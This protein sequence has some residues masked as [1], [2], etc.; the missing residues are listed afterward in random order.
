MPT[1]RTTVACL[2]V[3]TLTLAAGCERRAAPNEVPATPSPSTSPSTSP[4]ESP[5]PMTTPPMP[6]ASA[7]S[8]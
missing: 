5:T 3:A 6:S 8:Q 4:S 7:A 1:L 2:A